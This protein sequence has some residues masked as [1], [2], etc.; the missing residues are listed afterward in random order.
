[1]PNS[2]LTQFLLLPK[3]KLIKIK[4]LDQRKGI[5]YYCETK[6]THSYCPHCGLESRS[7]H[8]RRLVEIKDAPLWERKRIL[9]I[10]KKRFRCPGLGCKKVFTENIPGINKYARLSEKMQ[11]HLLH[12]TSRY[13]N[14]KEAKKDLKIGTKTLYQRHYKQLELEHRKI[15][16]NP[17][18]KTIGIDEHSFIR[19]KDYGYREFATIIVDYNNNRVKELIPGK[20][21]GQLQQALSYIPGRENVKNICMDL[22]STYRSFARDF[23]PNANIVADK[24]HVLKLLNPTMNKLRKRY[25]GD[26]RKA[27]VGKLLLMN[28][29]RLD[30]FTKKS[31]WDW[32]EDK[33]ELK[34]VYFAREALFKLYRCKGKKWAKKSLI[35]LTDYMANSKIKAIKTLRKTLLSW[36]EEILN[37]FTTKLTNAKTEGYNTVCKQ[38]QRRAY[39]LKNFN[40]YRLKVLYA[41]R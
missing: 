20:V 4:T 31:I 9:K 17:W 13:A 21:S 2:K 22:S 32:L 40:N 24:F 7:I 29:K 23:F 18:P 30:Y 3:L 15:K 36:S 34:E 19:N 8:D 25:V 26:R 33:P 6:T 27:R 1:M 12:I 14:L 38:L 41:C 35:K 28:S 37:Y 10:E 39:G 11:R 5:I 16:N